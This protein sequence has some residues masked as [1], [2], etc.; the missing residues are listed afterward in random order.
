MTTKTGGRYES[1]IEEAVSKRALNELGVASVKLVMR[2]A[3][4]WPDRLYW[5][6]G[7]VPLVHEYK[8]PGEEPEGL[9]ADR[10]EYLRKIK[11]EIEVHDDA[12]LAF[13]SVKRA[14]ER[15]QV[16]EKGKKLFAKQRV[17]SSVPRPRS[18]KD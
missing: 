14:L 8:R 9:Q 5:I 1:D 13:Q 4:G 3:S 2:Y 18:R 12:D 16:S 17:R 15:A 11:Y 10:I 6:P 7:G